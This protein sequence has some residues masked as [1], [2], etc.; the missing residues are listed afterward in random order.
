MWP[1]PQEIV[2]LVTF[3]DEIFNEKSYFLWDVSTNVRIEQLKITK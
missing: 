1:N 3:T 2:D